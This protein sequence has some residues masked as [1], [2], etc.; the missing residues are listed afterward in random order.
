MTRTTGPIDW[1]KEDSG[2]HATAFAL[3]RETFRFRSEMTPLCKMAQDELID[4][5]NHGNLSSLVA[6]YQ[7]SHNA[8]RTIGESVP[9][10]EY[11]I[12]ELVIA[13]FAVAQPN[14]TFKSW[15]DSTAHLVRHRIE[16][17]N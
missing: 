8:Q 1:N 10:T 17:K 12:R 13:C 6:A 2:K 5:V 11:M 15:Y 3:I 9:W 7:L 4:W 16:H 14:T